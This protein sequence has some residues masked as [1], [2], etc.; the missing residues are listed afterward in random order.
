MTNNEETNG[1]KCI[2]RRN[3][4]GDCHSSCVKPDPDMTGVPHGVRHGWFCYPWNFDPIW[5][6]KRC[7]HYEARGEV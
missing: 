1:Y 3:I 6:G 2:Y 5:K 7:N 4:P